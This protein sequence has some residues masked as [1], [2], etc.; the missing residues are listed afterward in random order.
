MCNYMIIYLYIHIYIHTYAN[1][2]RRNKERATGRE[3]EKA[4]SPP[5][6]MRPAILA[7]SV[8][9]ALSR[10]GYSDNNS[11]NTPRPPFW[12][13]NGEARTRCRACTS[14]HPPISF[15]I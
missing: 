2:Q 13:W 8:P 7:P 9:F 11:T 1:A 10:Y 4:I 3:E 14:R 15:S 12:N 5:L 6:S